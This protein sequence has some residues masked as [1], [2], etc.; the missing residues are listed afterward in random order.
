MTSKISCFD[1]V[2]FRR[3]LRKTLPLWACYLLVWL[4][5]LPGTLLNFDYN[6]EYYRSVS[7]TI[8]EMIL[9]TSTV[10]VVLSAFIGLLAA[11]GLF[12]WL[13]KTGSAY[14]Y[15]S[16]PVRR[17][18]L[19]VTNC[20]IG[21]VM[22]T[23]VHAITALVTFLITAMHGYAQPAACLSFFGIST[24]SFVCFY[25]FAVLLSIIIAQPAAMPAVY[26]LL[27]FTAALLYV[28]VKDLLVDFVYGM[29]DWWTVWSATPL[30]YRL[31]PVYYVLSRGLST[32]YARLP[33]GTIDYYSNY[34]FGDWGYLAAIAAAGLVFA[35]LA[36]VL[37]RRREMERSGDVIAFKS[38]RPVFLYCFTIGC[39]IVFTY[40]FSSMQTTA[41]YGARAFRKT[42]VFLVLGA[43]IGYFLAQ[44]LLKKTIAVFRGVKTW[45]GLGAVC[46]VLVLG[47]TAARLDIFGV[48]SRVPDVSDIS[49]ID[50]AY[51]GHTSDPSDFEAITQFQKL[52]I[53]RRRD[54]EVDNNEKRTSAYISYHLKDGTIRNY[55]Y[56]MSAEP[57]QLENPDS[58]VNHFDAVV[59]SESMILSRSAIPDA[60]AQDERQFALCT[61]GD[62]YAAAT[63]ETSLPRYLTGKEAYDFYTNC[64]LPDLLDTD[65]GISHVASQT[66][67]DDLNTIIISVSFTIKPT[68]DA[69]DRIN[70]AQP[71]TEDYSASSYSTYYTYQI[72][73]NAR[74]SAA[75]LESLGYSFDGPLG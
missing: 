74:R 26:V 68:Q 4:F 30:A 39:S 8:C 46:L 50:L 40:V 17:E 37:F 41:V 28:A 25:G 45:V 55:G 23:G 31:S 52:L 67:Q 47:C 11:W 10:A 33:D 62:D 24:L 36:L 20:S 32:Q 42:L 48:Y 9:N 35:A 29:T 71:D 57:A 3:S 73:K 38:L 64:I 18:T 51:C 12:S 15:A 43:A 69:I 66:K 2:I 59:N 27:N 13:F 7:G 70:A 54:N 49:Y 53:E 19:F 56:Q 75:F 72:T 16:L 5:I 1:G 44:M 58:L 60:F 65:L 21:F 63:G 61:I 22:V 34:T 6:P 14:F